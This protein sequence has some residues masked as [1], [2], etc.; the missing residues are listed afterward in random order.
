[1][2]KLCVG[3]AWN[4]AYNKL[5]IWI[6]VH[7]DNELTKHPCTHDFQIYF[8][9]FQTQHCILGLFRKLQTWAGAKRN[10]V[11]A[12][13]CHPILL[14]CRKNCWTFSIFE[15]LPINMEMESSCKTKDTIWRLSMNVE[16]STI[17]I[18]SNFVIQLLK[19]VQLERGLSKVH[20]YAF[21][22][23]KM[24]K[25]RGQIWTSQI[26]GN[27]PRVHIKLL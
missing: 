22:I 13:Y 15:K 25:K 5:C 11:I 27:I 14:S 18:F 20:L 19:S 9:K 10:E 6:F 2:K 21:V 17:I 1:V 3:N 24:I 4:L 7:N 12:S 26:C 8:T 16:I 23:W